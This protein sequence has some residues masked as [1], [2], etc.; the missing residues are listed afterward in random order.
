ML[1]SKDLNAN[2]TLDHPDALNFIN[3]NSLNQESETDHELQ[4]L[5]T[6]LSK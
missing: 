2:T 5:P 3:Y 6:Y 1:F 4:E